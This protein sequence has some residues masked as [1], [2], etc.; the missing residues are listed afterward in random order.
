MTKTWDVVRGSMT[1]FSISVGVSEKW[2]SF[3]EEASSQENQTSVEARRYVQHDEAIGNRTICQL[4]AFYR[5]S[6]ARLYATFLGG[7]VRIWERWYETH[8][9]QC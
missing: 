3:R 1:M 5:N 4:H 8:A 2:S 6:T 7:P 9:S